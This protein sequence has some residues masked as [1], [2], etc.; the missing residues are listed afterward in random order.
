MSTD[1]LNNN[2]YLKSNCIFIITC[3]YLAVITALLWQLPGRQIAEQ[4][5][6]KL[7]NYYSTC[8]TDHRM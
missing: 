8:I 6:T 3:E 7:Y 5:S 2:S 1:F 4:F